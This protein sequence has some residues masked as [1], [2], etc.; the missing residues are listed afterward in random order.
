MTGV[1]DNQQLEGL[2]KRFSPWSQFLR[3]CHIKIQSKVNKHE[4]M[5]NRNLLGIVEVSCILLVF[6]LGWL[7][8]I[9]ES[10]EVVLAML[11]L[12]IGLEPLVERGLLALVVLAVDGRS[13]RLSEGFSKQILRLDLRHVTGIAWHMLS[14][15]VLCWTS[16]PVLSLL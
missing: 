14:F 12:S 10:T 3:T 15:Q 5:C 11:C 4:E 6:H 16:E 13:S 2:G 1:P 8:T 9:L 7:H